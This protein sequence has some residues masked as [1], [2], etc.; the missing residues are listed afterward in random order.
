M[1]SSACVQAESALCEQR[2]DGAQA[3]RPAARQ[4]PEGAANF[5]FLGQFASVVD[6][7]RDRSICDFNAGR[8]ALLSVSSNA[9]LAP[10]GFVERFLIAQRDQAILVGFRGA[11]GPR[12]P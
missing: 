8:T 6:G 5:G 1:A 12:R 10:K 9:S 4:A 11:Y 7:A 2:V 3:Q